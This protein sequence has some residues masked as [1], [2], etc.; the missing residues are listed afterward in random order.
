VS[1]LIEYLC[2]AFQDDNWPDALTVSADVAGPAGK[3]GRV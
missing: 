3:R 1:V 2:S